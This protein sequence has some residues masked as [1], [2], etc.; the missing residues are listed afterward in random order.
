MVS[1]GQFRTAPDQVVQRAIDKKLKV[2]GGVEATD[3]IW[4]VVDAEPQ[5]S[6]ANIGKL[7]D[8]KLLADGAGINVTISNP[9]FEHW[10]RL[11]CRDC[12]GAHESAQACKAAFRS[13]VQGATKSKKKRKKVEIEP[14]ITMKSIQLARERARQQH[15]TKG[16]QPPHQCDPNVTDMYKMIDALE[17]LS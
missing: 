15:A 10:L 8:A 1:E 12:D 7:E 16:K 5:A 9:C 3:Q 13:E 11:H 17:G 6:H 14:L 2:E 4:A